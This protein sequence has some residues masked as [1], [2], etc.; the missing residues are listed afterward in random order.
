MKKIIL[1]LL[2]LIF[3]RVVL[4][5][6]P[7]YSAFDPIMFNVQP[8]NG[9]IG[10]NTNLFPE[11][12]TL[13]NLFDTNGAA[14]YQ[15]AQ[16]TNFSLL[17]GQNGTNYTQLVGQNVTNLITT[18]SN[19][20]QAQFTFAPVPLKGLFA[21]YRA[22]MLTNVATGTAVNQIPD[23]TGN[24]NN[25]LYPFGT[26]FNGVYNATIMN[27]LPG[28][29]QTANNCCW[30]NANMFNAGYSNSTIFMVYRDT[31]QNPG[32]EVDISFGKSGNVPA[33]F[34]DYTGNGYGMG[35]AGSSAAWA[36]LTSTVTTTEFVKQN[37][38]VGIETARFSTNGIDPAM[39]CDG[40]QTIQ[41]VTVPTVGARSIVLT[42]GIAVGGYVGAA[43][44]LTYN[45]YISEILIYT[46]NLSTLAIGQVN[47]YLRNKYGFN[48]KSL[49]FT[50]DSQAVGVFSL[51]NSN[52]VNVLTRMLPDWN[53]T[54]L[55]QSGRNSQQTWTNFAYTVQNQKWPGMTAVMIFPDFNNAGSIAN[56]TN[57]TFAT[58]QLARTNGFIPFLVTEWSSAVDENTFPGYRTNYNNWVYTN[59]QNYGVQ[60]IVDLATNPNIGPFGSWTNLQWF[61]AT[62]VDGGIAHL[63]SNSYPAIVGPAIASEL[64]A[65]MFTFTGSLSGTNSHIPIAVTVGTSPFNFTNTTPYTLECYF[66][67]AAAYSVAKN[68]AT[69]FNAASGNSYFLFGP[70]NI[71]TVTYSSTTPTFTTNAYQ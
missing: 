64:K 12:G 31:P 60:G 10:I 43:T 19:A 9:Y 45:G 48:N 27:G 63:N 5:V 51:Q 23:F 32:G 36:L 55:G 68:G 33:A 47:T 6:N 61:I 67:D 29:Q 1:I 20:F 37:S 4:A 34:I 70:T 25:T 40:V 2:V 58:I 14:L 50:G 49:L 59:W 44:A 15:G 11:I 13:T 57:Y 17:L 7:P 39:W 41:A 30:T 21:W 62:N 54:G 65:A 8:Q 53:C 71:L 69:V 28:F 66:T 24:P 16:S 18:T 26:S 46:N 22:D 38:Q 35:V 52:T 56:V 42:N 3:C